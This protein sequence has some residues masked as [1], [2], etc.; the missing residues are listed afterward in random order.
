MNTNLV[1][2]KD[3][4]AWYAPPGEL[5]LRICRQAYCI[6]FYIHN[7]Y[8]SCAYI[9]HL[10]ASPNGGAPHFR[11]DFRVSHWVC[12][13]KHSCA[14]N[15]TFTSHTGRRKSTDFDT[16]WLGSVVLN[17]PYVVAINR[18]NPKHTFHHCHESLES[19]RKDLWEMAILSTLSLDRLSHPGASYS[20]LSWMQ[21]QHCMMHGRCSCVI[22][23]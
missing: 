12:T 4:E 10:V 20:K 5:L 8:I 3:T 16:D 11:Q 15:V 9:E 23:A 19:S 1:V 21:S 13:A 2:G 14:L 17:I 6:N 18:Q 22:C 7:D